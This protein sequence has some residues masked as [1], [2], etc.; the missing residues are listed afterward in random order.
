M[1]Y[2]T[3]KMLANISGMKFMAYFFMKTLDRAMMPI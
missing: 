1:G 2:S 3:Q